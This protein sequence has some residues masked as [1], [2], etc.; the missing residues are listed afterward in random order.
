M[1]KSCFFLS[2]SIFVLAGCWSVGPDYKAPE[3]RKPAH[4]LPDAGLPLVSNKLVRSTTSQ[5]TEITTNELASWWTVFHDD[6]LTGLVVDAFRSNLTLRASLTRV[7][8]ARAKLAAARGSWE[9]TLDMGGSYSRFRTSR[10]GRSGVRVTQGDFLGEFDAKWEI[11]IFGGTRRSVEA[12][13][14]DLEAE[15]A[16]VDQV[17]VS[18]AAE[19]AADYIELRTIQDRLQVARDN[20]KVQQETLDILASRN[21]AGIG[22]DLAVQQ[23]RYNVETTR[24]TIPVLLVEE[25]AYINSLAILTGREPGAL[26]QMLRGSK[27]HPLI[28]PRKLVGIDAELLRRRPDVRKAERALAAQ[29]ARIGVARADLYPRFFLNGSIGL[30]SI[31]SSKFF[32]ADSLFWNFGPSFSWKIF[33]GNSVRAG[34]EIQ[35][36]LYDAAAAEYEL[37][38]LNAQKEIR[39]ALTAYGQGFHRYEALSKAVEAAQA[40][41]NISQDLYRNGLRDF[42]NVLDA[43]RSLL[44]LQEALTISEGNI[45]VFLIKLYKALGGGWAS[46]ESDAG[47]TRPVASDTTDAQPAPT[48]E[49][50]LR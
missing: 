5:R 17:W 44:S 20:L 14:R 31:D 28:E 15:V 8:Q 18:L 34:I 2:V 19:V 30:E 23:A 50:L 36:A 39:D 10:N 29:C 22:D 13:E 37:T 21:K 26:H 9:P 6:Q 16:G 46:W 47:G 49:P 3:V 43:Q 48:V 1:K 42:N 12:A 33:S 4:D 32:K 41:V 35:N 11:D 24:A 27:S 25:E 7:R 40:A 45:G 38:L